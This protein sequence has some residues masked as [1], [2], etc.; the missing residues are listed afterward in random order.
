MVPHPPAIL[1][2]DDPEWDPDEDHQ[3]EGGEDQLH[4]GGDRRHDV[5]VDEDARLRRPPVPLEEVHKVVEELCQDWLVL[6]RLAVLDRRHPRVGVPGVADVARV[7]MREE[8]RE[9]DD[10][11][12]DGNELDEPLS[13]ENSE[14]SHAA[15]HLDRASGE[16]GNRRP[17]HRGR[18]GVPLLIR[19]LGRFSSRRA[20]ITEDN[21]AGAS[22]TPRTSRG[23]WR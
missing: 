5:W 1:G 6:G 7:Q 15:A 22:S 10:P 18:Y 17:T 8:E 16:R 19:Q 2:R 12:Q 21:R 3:E 23:R 13:D 4:R 9:D 14:V 20:R 11:E